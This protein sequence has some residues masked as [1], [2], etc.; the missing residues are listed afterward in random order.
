MKKFA[1]YLFALI[2]LIISCKRDDKQPQKVENNPVV[3]TTIAVEKQFSPELEYS[4]TFFPNREANLGASMPGKIEKFFYPEGTFVT[5]GTLLVEM[6]AELLT[7]ALIEYDAI[8]KDFERVERLRAKGSIS[9][10]EYD[11]LKAK[12]EASE[13]KTEMLHKNT[14]VV[15]PFDGIIVEYLVEEG[16]NY[17]FNLNFD[18]GYSNT[19][20]ILRLM[21]INPLVVKIQ[22]NEKELQQ[23][24]SGQK[25]SIMCD[26]VSGNGLTGFVKYI[27]PMLSTVTR[28]AEV[29]IEVPNPGNRLKPGMFARVLLHTEGSS[30]VFVP[31]DAIYRQPGT[32][33]DFIFVVHSGVAHQM[34]VKRIAIIDQWVAVSGISKGDTIVTQGKNK[35][36]DNQQV[37]IK[38]N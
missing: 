23:L 10:I 1:I 31:V 3:K 8:K 17:F 2:L 19:S 27:K 7:Q 32:P 26:A 21:Q 9:E 25:V 37:I 34:A 14:S 36:K 35:L 18:P 4:G 33:D 22:V 6:S 20:G 15:A 12:L 11:H 28:T 30:A 5:S 38:N 16:E 24:K 13:V 29:E